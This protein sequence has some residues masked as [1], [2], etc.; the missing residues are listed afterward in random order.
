LKRSLRFGP[1]VLYAERRQLLRDGVEIHL[2]RK[3]FDLLLL[4]VDRAP[5]V[6]TKTE[7]H[8]H[9]WPA[10]FVADS[11]LVGLVKEVRRALDDPPGET[12]IRTVHR[13]GYAFA[14]LLEPAA[15]KPSAITAHWLVVGSTRIPLVDEENVIGRDPQATVWL[16]VP[17][18]SRR[19]ARITLENGRAMLEDLGSKNGT[20]VGDQPVRTRVQLRHADRIQ[21]ATE[22]LV[23]HQS[24]A[25]ISTATQPLARQKPQ[26][27]AT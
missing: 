20:L 15:S 7:I 16:D 13:V 5:A 3:A 23:F 11:T 24:A 14:A 26:R 25:G 18:V 17:G 10:T 12:R 21:I 9:L 2:T 19:H 8:E 22:V 27:K 4:L 1:F 6:V